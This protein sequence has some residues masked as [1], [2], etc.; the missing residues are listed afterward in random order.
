[1]TIHQNE[2]AKYGKIAIPYP[3]FA[4]QV[5]AHRFT[6]PV[7]ALIAAAA[8]DIIEMAPIPRGCTVV[9]MILDSDDLDT[10]GTPAITMDVGIMS[11]VFGDTAQDRTIG[12]EFFS[13]STVGQAGG[14]V[15]PTLKTAQ[16][17]AASDTERSIGIKIGTAAD[18]G[19]AGTVGLTIFYAAA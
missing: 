3:S 7:T 6:F 2:V 10:D 4:G 1:M 14:L 9:D 5:V 11:G 12:A 16:R 8:G 15:R 19:A 17:V 18:A 13:G